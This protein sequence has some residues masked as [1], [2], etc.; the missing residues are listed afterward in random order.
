MELQTAL[1]GKFFTVLTTDPTL[2]TAMGGTWDGTSNPW[3]YHVWAK[4]DAAMP[5]MVHRIDLQA[6]SDFWPI[7]QGTYLL[8][9]WS[10]SEKI[11]E[12]M[13]I[14]DRIMTLL[15]EQCWDIDDG[16]GNTVVTACRVWLQTEGFVPEQTDGIIHYVT[17]WNL[18]FYRT[19]EVNNILSR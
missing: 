9:I 13:A 3:L 15:D 11:D 4:P 6:A 1:I 7:R 14:R 12:A 2:A 5:Y 17:Q 18:R 16:E 8:D 10:S 19:R